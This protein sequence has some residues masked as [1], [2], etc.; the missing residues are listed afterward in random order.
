MRWFIATLYGIHLPKDFCWEIK[1]KNHKADAITHQR[2]SLLL[3]TLF[4]CLRFASPEK[5]GQWTKTLSKTL[6]VIAQHKGAN[7]QR[8]CQ[9]QPSNS[10]DVHISLLV[11]VVLRVVVGEMVIHQG[12]RRHFC[13]LSAL[14]STRESDEHLYWLSSR[15][16]SVHVWI[17]CETA[18]VQ[19][20]ARY[21][22]YGTMSPCEVS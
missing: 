22:S 2:L 19:R 17:C 6:T 11:G 20:I 1:P 12:K 5:S 21:S 8:Q 7:T 10:A 15:L 4:V 16:L 14:F 3:S 9:T 13:F 18:C